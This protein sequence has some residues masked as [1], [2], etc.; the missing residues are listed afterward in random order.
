MRDLRP[1]YHL[2]APAGW[3]NDPNALVHRDGRYHL[4]YQHNPA[5]TAWGDI[6][7][8]HAVTDDLV[9]WRHLPLALRPTP[10][11]PDADGCWSGCL[12]DDNGTPTVVYSGFVYPSQIG[13]RSVCLARGDEPLLTWRADPRSPVLDGPPTGLDVVAFRDPFV[14]RD[15]D[16][17]SLV[18]GSG[19]GDERPALLAYRSADLLDW[20]YTGVLA[21]GNEGRAWECPQLFP[22]GDGHVL[23]VSTWD[24]RHE[25]HTQHAL[26]LVGE[27]GDGQFR[28]ET[29]ARFDHGAECYA[30][31]TAL[32]A[33]GRRLA[34]AWAWEARSDEAAREQGCAGT[35][36]LPRVLTLRGD[37][38]VG[39]EPV[40]EVA[41]LRGE[42]EA[43][44]SRSLG[45][46]ESLALETRGDCVELLLHAALSPRATISLE[47]CRSPEG[48][49]RTVLRFSRANGRLELDRSS[50]SLD[51]RAARG[52]HGGQLELGRDEL[53]EL[54]VFVD[55]SIVEVFANGRFALTERIY[56][57][58]DDSTGLALSVADGKA[59]IDRLEVWALS[60]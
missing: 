11:G 2:T 13:A 28:V 43:P 31:T 29:T 24:D 59:T 44:S 34:M 48:E 33:S 50:S 57:T 55:R 56:P 42:L 14:W 6:H 16:G 36:T 5:S 23:L 38:T 12:V 32:D 10:G 27:L 47:L 22:L 3:L 9:R 37:R 49:E 26:A 30:P 15:G 60:P 41:S 7:W 21:T 25:R 58:R 17:W 53:L 4:L 18:M 52:V 54:R 1:R 40:S 39:I 35:M 45:A 8:G 46:G 51:P 19:L 20:S